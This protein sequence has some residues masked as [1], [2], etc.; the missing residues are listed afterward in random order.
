MNSNKKHLPLL[1]MLRIV[2][3]SVIGYLLYSLNFATGSKTG[4]II[5][6]ALVALL[7]TAVFVEKHIIK[8]VAGKTK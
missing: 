6:C 4:K 7:L 3:T 2:S 8:F 1:I 5:V